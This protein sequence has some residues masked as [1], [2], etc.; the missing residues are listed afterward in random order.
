MVTK[1]TRNAFLALVVPALAW[2]HH[3]RV[4]APE[5]RVNVLAE[6]APRA[7]ATH[8]GRGS[9]AAGRAGPG[10]RAVFP[11]FVLG[12]LGAAALRTVGDVALAHGAA[13][14]WLDR[15]AWVRTTSF[16]G[17]VLGSRYL[18]VGRA[19]W[20]PALSAR[21]CAVQGTAM[22]AVGLSTSASV[23]R[24]VGPR[25]LLVGCAGALA[26]GVV[27]AT[28]TLLL[29]ARLRTSSGASERNAGLPAGEREVK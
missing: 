22:A 7:Q 9:T 27:S 3:R 19:F 25:P 28:A 4:R 18:L 14:V 16:V 15:A 5:E 29:G 21:G 20:T 6:G 13:P 8:E 26:V 24:G 2:H 12:F 17:D 10:L 23:L 11:L 1:L